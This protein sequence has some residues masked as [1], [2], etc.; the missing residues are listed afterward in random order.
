MRR[1]TVRIGGGIGPS[2]GPCLWAIVSLPGSFNI[3]IVQQ[4]TRWVDNGSL[5]LALGSSLGVAHVGEVAVAGADGLRV[6]GRGRQC[7]AGNTKGGAIVG[8]ADGQPQRP[9]ERVSSGHCVGAMRW[10]AAGEGEESSCHVC[11]WGR[12]VRSPSVLRL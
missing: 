12:D 2:L 9:D 7:A 3:A 1:D 11:R 5:Q 6:A 10:A 8:S 4:R